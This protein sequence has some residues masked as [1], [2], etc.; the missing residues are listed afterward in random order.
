MSYVDVETSAEAIKE[1][2]ELIE[3]V[4]QIVGK[5]SK[6]II[7]DVKNDVSGFYFQARLF[8]DNLFPF[9]VYWRE[10]RSLFWDDMGKLALS[11][12]LFLVVFW[13]LAPS[14][15]WVKKSSSWLSFRKNRGRVSAKRSSSLEHMKFKYLRSL[16]PFCKGKSK[17][18][19]ERSRS[20]SNIDYK[21]GLSPA[22]IIE[23][24]DRE[25]EEEKFLKR[26]PSILES[27][28]SFLVLP[29][30]C[31]RMEK[32]KR[33]LEIGKEAKEKENNEKLAEDHPFNRL[34]AYRRQFLHLMITFLRY[35]YN[36]AGLAL[37]NWTEALLKTRQNRGEPEDE[38]DDDQSEAG[39]LKASVISSEKS[40]KGP[41]KLTP[42]KAGLRSKRDTTMKLQKTD[43]LW[44][45]AVAP[46]IGESSSD[47][48]SQTH[49]GLSLEPS[50]I[51]ESEEKKES[52]MDQTGNVVGSP[53][54]T[55]RPFLSRPSSPSSIYETP[56]LDAS[57]KRELDPGEI[58]ATRVISSKSLFVGTAKRKDSLEVRE[59]LL[60]IILSVRAT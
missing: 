3:A 47:L 16:S 30:E 21:L 12:A 55:P 5:A 54:R 46:D 27:K 35:D 32:P 26:W 18:A 60:C 52:P 11:G 19:L 24:E 58:L 39:S 29:P 45:D 41:V 13:I 50:M 53:P 23:E 8:F 4:E 48:S 49:L 14:P 22:E 42:E 44:S 56:G 38:D 6:A 37:I 9:L 31:K 51:N 57:D 20:T 17:P 10:D 28:Y 7:E 40:E 33:Q 1:D 2:E 15:Q 36:G 34:I 59:V 43:Q 25:T